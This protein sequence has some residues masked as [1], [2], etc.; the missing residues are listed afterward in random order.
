MTREPVTP[1]YVQ[2][3]RGEAA[4]LGHLPQSISLTLVLNFELC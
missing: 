2:A 3:A 4:R 1:Q